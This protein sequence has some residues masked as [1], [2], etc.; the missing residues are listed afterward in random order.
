MKTTDYTEPTDTAPLET[1]PTFAVDYFVDDR[2]RPSRVML[3]PRALEPG[4]S[5]QWVSIDADH[6]VP[7]DEVR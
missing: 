6:A 7:L 2:E 3:M 5:D 1:L 4:S